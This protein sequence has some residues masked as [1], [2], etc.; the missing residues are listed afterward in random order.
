MIV[1]M[2][3]SLISPPP[4]PLFSFILPYFSK[5]EAGK[6]KRLVFIWYH[7]SV[8]NGCGLLGPQPSL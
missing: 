5:K 2:K 1:G 7:E 6:F 3:T 8:K 4:S